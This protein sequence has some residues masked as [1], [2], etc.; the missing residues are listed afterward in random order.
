MKFLLLIYM[1]PAIWDSLTDEE[2]NEV[3]AGH[4]EF[5]KTMLASGEMISTHALAEPARSTVVRVR[6]DAPPVTDG[7]YIEAKE[8]MAGYYVVECASHERAN[9]LAA[10]L[11]DARFNAIEVRPIVFSS[12]LNI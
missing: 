10:M 11:P 3:F 4:T 6:D 7:P 2:R 8:Y 12:G 5:Q 9:E 1:N